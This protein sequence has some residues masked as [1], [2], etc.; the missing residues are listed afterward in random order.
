MLNLLK[1]LSAVVPSE[2]DKAYQMLKSAE[3]RFRIYNY[4]DQAEDIKA[5]LAKV[6]NM[7]VVIRDDAGKNMFLRPVKKRF[8]TLQHLTFTLPPTMIPKRLSFLS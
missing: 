8:L 6:G 7:G 1:N 3:I 5:F 4:K 2:N